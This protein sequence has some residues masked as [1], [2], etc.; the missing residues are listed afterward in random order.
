LVND[1]SFFTSSDFF[2]ATVTETL[3]EYLFLKSSSAVIVGW[4]VMGGGLLGSCLEDFSSEEKLTL[5]SK[6]SRFF[7]GWH[8]YERGLKS[9]NFSYSPAFTIPFFGD[10]KNFLLSLH[11][12]LL[13]TGPLLIFSYAIYSNVFYMSV[14][15]YELFWFSFWKV[16][17]RRLKL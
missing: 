14:K 13:L 12:L 9:L 2:L 17:L 16:D 1:S 7:N 15:Y 10:S 4:V 3:R 8:D 11:P 5:E 6:D